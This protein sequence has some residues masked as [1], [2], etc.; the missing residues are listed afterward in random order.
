MSGPGSRRG[1]LR[2]LATLPLI[3]GSVALVGTPRATAEP[4]TRALLHDYASWLAAECAATSHEAFGQPGLL[5]A[6]CAQDVQQWH[7]ERWPG[8]RFLEPPSARAALVLA[9]VGCDWRGR[10]L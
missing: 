4:C 7:Q 8:A 10:A 2:G 1:F 9:T 5:P 6:E 3:G